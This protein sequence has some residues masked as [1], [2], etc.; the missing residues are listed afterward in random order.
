VRSP[1]PL[2]HVQAVARIDRFWTVTFGRAMC[3]TKGG[4]LCSISRGDFGQQ[5]GLSRSEVLAEDHGVDTL[6]I[7]F[8]KHAFGHE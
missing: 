2:P 6:S 4:M 7:G 8:P 3:P 1:A 5:L